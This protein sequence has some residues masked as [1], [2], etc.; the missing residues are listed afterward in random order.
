MTC[1]FPALEQGFANYI[2]MKRLNDNIIVVAPGAVSLPPR[3]KMAYLMKVLEP[4][5]SV[6]PSW[7][8]YRTSYHM[9]L[10]IPSQALK[11]FQC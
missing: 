8:I 7:S 5:Q 6:H 1:I 9:S 3:N 11:M 4:S 10:H 2:R